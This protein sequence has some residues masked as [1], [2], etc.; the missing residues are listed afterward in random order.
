MDDSLLF[1]GS[2]LSD[3]LLLRYR[4]TSEKL[5]LHPRPPGDTLTN[6]T[7]LPL[8]GAAPEPKRVRLDSTASTGSATELPSTVTETDSSSAI[9]SSANHLNFDETDVELYG[10]SIQHPTPQFMDIDVFN[11]EQV[12]DCLRNIGPMANITAGEVPCLATGQTDPSD[13]VLTAAQAEMAHIELI[14]SIARPLTSDTPH[15]QPAN[16]AVGGGIALLHRSVRAHGLTAFELPEYN[17]LWSLYGPP[18]GTFGEKESVKEEEGEEEHEKENHSP[19]NGSVGNDEAVEDAPTKT[20]SPDPNA[21]SHEEKENKIDILDTEAVGDVFFFT[22]TTAVTTTISSILIEFGSY[23][24]SLSSLLTDSGPPKEN[25]DGAEVITESNGESTQQLP[26]EKEGEETTAE[27]GKQPSTPPPPPASSAE[28]HSYLLLTR[29]DSTMILEVGEEIVE[30]EVS[31]FN[32]TET[33]VIA[34]N[35]GQIH[36]QR[37]KSRPLGSMD[38]SPSVE[39]APGEPTSLRVGKDYPYILQVNTHT[40]VSGPYPHL[41]FFT[42][43]FYPLFITVLFWRYKQL[44]RTFNGNDGLCGCSKKGNQGL[45]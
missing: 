32:T 26:Q 15:F 3:S 10:P 23:S 31:G 17:S 41:T 11:F 8:A 9:N 27:A 29:E 33:T 43:L 40:L 25:S 12:L 5:G 28:L 34:A 22:I 35:L 24:Y 2:S 36:S 18:V 19:V 30:L 21:F 39:N 42:Q 38:A 44:W 1:I 16:S 45:L 20:D 13:E 6:G 37:S 4:L 14:A 7:I